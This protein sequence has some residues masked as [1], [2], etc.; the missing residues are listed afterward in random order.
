M[1]AEEVTFSFGRNWTN[2]LGTVGVE[3]VERAEADIVE[4]LGPGAVRGKDVI[5]IG[6]GSGIHS[7]VFNR[8][9]ARRVHS[10]DYDPFSVEATK[11]LWTMRGEPEEW[12]VEH[13]SILDQE[14]LDSLGHFDIVYSWGVLHHTGE[15][16][17]AIRNCFGLVRKDG[18]VWIAL[19]QKGPRYAADLALK[20]KYNSSSDFG[21]RLMV[22]RRILRI[23]LS[24]ARH[25]KNPFT[26]N[27]KS[28]R[29]MNRYHDLVD[30]LG[31][32]PYEVA[33][34]DEVVK[35][36]A[37]SNLILERIKVVD[38]GGCSIYVF[39]KAT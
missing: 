15:M 9:G 24:R 32:L 31:G 13:G 21:K 33:S 39:R 16:W 3:E 22:Y 8:L 18:V 35:V 36:A 5:D 30:W 10:F 29:G 38:E 2:F 27:E 20:R 1:S 25:F 28:P 11:K 23:M 14:Y 6:S 19:Y 4:W 34:E 7:L 26:W 17:E 12:S 37:E